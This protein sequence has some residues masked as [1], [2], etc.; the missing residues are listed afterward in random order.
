MLHVG[1]HRLKVHRQLQLGAH[2]KAAAHSVVVE[3]KLLPVK[4]SQRRVAVALL[5]PPLARR[6]LLLLLCCGELSNAT[7]EIEQHEPLFVVTTN[8]R[9]TQVEN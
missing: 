9:V 8:T 5:L 1:G 3:L 2:V 4:K 7:K 6:R